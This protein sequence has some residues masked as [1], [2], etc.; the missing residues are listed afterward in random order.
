MSIVIKNDG[1]GKHQSVSASFSLMGNAGRSGW[2]SI[3]LTG[4]G[5]DEAEA[6]DELQTQALDLMDTLKTLVRT[7]GLS[8]PEAEK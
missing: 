7:C 1:K 2:Q 5:A 4:W 8:T 3:E 6:R